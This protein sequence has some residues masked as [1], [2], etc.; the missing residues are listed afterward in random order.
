MATQELLSSH[1]PFENAQPRYL[2]VAQL[3]SKSITA[4]EY[5]VGSLLPTE[6][7]L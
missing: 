2:A 3:L 1:D 6:T 5:G 4:G 7:E